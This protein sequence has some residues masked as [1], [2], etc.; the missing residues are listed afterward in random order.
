MKTSRYSIA[1]ILCFLLISCF[2]NA[3]NV[4]APSVKELA[5]RVEASPANLSV[6]EEYIKAAADKASQ[7]K[8]QYDA[9][10]KK[11][12]DKA[13]IS[14]AIGKALLNDNDSTGKGYLL[15]AVTID[16]NFAPAWQA[17]YM[18]ELSVDNTKAAQRY[19]E[20]AKSIDRKNVQYAFDY[21]WAYRNDDQIKFDSLLVDL[22]ARFPDTEKAALA[23]CFA[24]QS[25]YNKAERKAYCDAL[26]KMDKKEQLPWVNYAFVEY[27]Q[28]LLTTDA[29]KAFEVALQMSL[30]I[31]TN[32]DLWKK[33]RQLAR[34]FLETRRSLKENRPHDAVAL[35]D[36]ETIGNSISTTIAFNAEPVLAM[37]KAEV[38]D[39][40]G[41]TQRAIDTL[42]AMYTVSPSKAIYD[43]MLNL[44][45]KAGL[46]SN[47]IYNSVK[48][49]LEA[50]AWAPTDFSLENY[51]DH[52]KVSLSDFKG[53]VVLLTFWFPTCSPCKA[54][55][56]HFESVLKNYDRS[57]VAYLGI[58]LNNSNP[59]LVMPLMA[60]AGYSFIPL[61]D[62]KNQ[63]KGNLPFI[64]SAPTN[65]LFDGRGRVV[66]SNFRVDDTN[67]DML[68]SMLEILLKMNK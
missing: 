4:K 33:R 1:F 12:P 47:A 46:D 50:K 29:E 15:K 13:A 19:A 16:T 49:V 55:F 28:D 44:G 66:F 9:W 3:Q 17:L 59:E 27:Y 11:Y 14:Y 18:A 39:A 57:K 25:A 32:R 56:P 61:M 36:K 45:Q 21:A 22:A 30:K 35:I 48:R 42:T 64:N 38:Y 26:L 60:N 8:P 68:E 7:L 31:K 54:E 40:A 52:K 6:H 43:K 65:Y 2:A 67:H 23:L 10:Q 34:S 53:K 51:A 62:A 58:N 24:S 63:S 5:K 41:L 37:L 20:K